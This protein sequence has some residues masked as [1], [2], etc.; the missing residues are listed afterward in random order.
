MQAEKRVVRITVAG[1]PSQPHR[2]IEVD[3]PQVRPMHFSAP[4]C[5]STLRQQ[6]CLANE[7]TMLYVSGANTLAAAAAQASMAVFQ[8]DISPPRF[9]QRLVHA[10]LK[11]WHSNPLSCHV[12]CGHTKPAPFYAVVATRAPQQT[13]ESAHIICFVSA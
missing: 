6:L 5:C 9:P 7:S 2:V 4:P 11:Q 12:D 8:S 10:T 1:P 13:V 3:D